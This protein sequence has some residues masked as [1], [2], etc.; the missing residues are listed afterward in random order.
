M[1]ITVFTSNQPRH[2]H[3]IKSLSKIADECFAVL[4]ANTV[5]PGQ[6]NDFFNK[7]D[8]FQTYFSHVMNAE[9]AIFGDLNFSHNVNQLILK[10]GDLNKIKPSVLEP[11]LHSDIYIVFGSS[12]I[13][14]WLIDFLVKNKAINIHM[15]ISPYYRGSACNF[16]SI[17][18]N[19]PHLTGATIHMLS[20]GLDS[21]DMLYH[22]A[23]TT[24]GC[25]NSFEFS[26]MTVK[27][28]HLSLVERIA[29][30]SILHYT[31]VRQ[32]KSQEIRYTR[33]ASFTDEVAEEFLSRSLTIEKIEQLLREK[34]GEISLL[35]PFYLKNHDTLH[36]N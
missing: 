20:K 4:E 25:K 32:D 2:L 36:S 27:S 3:L 21:G 30:N 33:N 29:D 6:V 14:G 28:A 31:P 24:E 18:D 13:K 19:N 5:F 17:Y 10:S 12:F 1:K 26:M 35:H 9:Q 34:H 7:S 16:W 11:A 8:V 23:P 22:V 15:G